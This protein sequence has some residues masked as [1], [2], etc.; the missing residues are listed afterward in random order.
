MAKATA[1]GRMVSCT[2]P[3]SARLWN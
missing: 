2:L 1:L 3:A